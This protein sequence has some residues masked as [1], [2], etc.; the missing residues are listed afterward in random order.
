MFCK[1]V[2]SMSLYWS[3]YNKCTEGAYCIYQHFLKRD[4]YF[5]DYSNKAQFNCDTSNKVAISKS[6]HLELFTAANI[7]ERVKYLNILMALHPY[8]I[9]N[10][11]FLLHISCPNSLLIRSFNHKQYSPSWRKLPH[12]IFKGCRCF[13]ESCTTIRFQH[14]SL[15]FNGLSY[16]T[17]QAKHWNKLDWYM[18]FKIPT[19]AWI[20]ST[21]S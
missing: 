20:I 15:C 21:A 19:V 7:R 14:K 16:I 13:L 10:N 6:S 2:G 12:R 4:Q 3:S 18:I 9:N 8:I 17:Y 5:L 11:E 1:T